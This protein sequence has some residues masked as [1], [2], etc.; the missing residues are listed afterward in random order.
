M[1]APVVSPVRGCGPD[2][3]ERGPS[4]GR[5]LSLSHSLAADVLSRTSSNMLSNATESSRACGRAG[6]IPPFLWFRARPEAPR[7]GVLDQATL[8]L[9]SILTGTRR[10]KTRLAAGLESMSNPASR[11]NSPRWIRRRTPSWPGASAFIRT[12]TDPPSR[13]SASNGV[14]PRKRVGPPHPA[15]RHL[16]G[17]QTAQVLVR[18]RLLGG[19]SSPQDGAGQATHKDPPVRSMS[20]S[21]FMA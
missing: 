16:R 9:R 3:G 14:F 10:R 21:E 15:M 8:A 1:A 5:L 7:S 6:V 19:G 11:S 18:R 4:A 20:C 12:A 2:S 17:C 13:L